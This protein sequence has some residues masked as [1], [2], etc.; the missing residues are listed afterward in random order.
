[1]T[2][3]LEIHLANFSGF[4]QNPK[5]FSIK[6]TKICELQ[7]LNCTFTRF[8]GKFCF[9]T[10]IPFTKSKKIYQKPDDWIIRF[11]KAEGITFEEYLSI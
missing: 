7:N 6:S 5:N 4:F 11:R 1:M 2:S 10:K 3:E 8:I 9:K